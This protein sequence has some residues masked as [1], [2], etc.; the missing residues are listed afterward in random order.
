[1][2]L[3]RPFLNNRL[4]TLLR[5]PLRSLSAVAA[6]RN[7]NRSRPLARLT[8]E[9]HI[10]RDARIERFSFGDGPIDLLLLRAFGQV[11]S[12]RRRMLADLLSDMPLDVCEATKVARQY[13]R[14]VF[15]ER[16]RLEPESSFHV[17]VTKTG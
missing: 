7:A 5:I 1:M 9:A 10:Y 2:N 12:D 16:L 14:S 15:P 6:F 4:R 11:E 3:F 13:V 17:S 8:V